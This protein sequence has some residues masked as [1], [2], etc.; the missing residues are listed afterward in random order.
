MDHFEF[1]IQRNIKKKNLAEAY[2]NLC[3]VIR[4]F[5]RMCNRFKTCENERLGDI[6]KV[7]SLKIPEFYHPTPPPSAQLARPCSF[8]FV[9]F[10][11]I[12]HTVII[13]NRKNWRTIKLHFENLSIFFKK[14]TYTHARTLPPSP[15]SFLFTFQWIP[16]PTPTSMNIHFERPLK[17]CPTIK[18]GKNYPFYKCISLRQLICRINFVA[19]WLDWLIVV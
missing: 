7:R 13:I 5:P 4:M 17:A 9:M 1:C 6:Q 16:P 15:C 18:V 3:K 2:S 11:L 12:F 14:R 19:S 8:S 10:C